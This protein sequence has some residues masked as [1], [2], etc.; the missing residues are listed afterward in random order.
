[1]ANYS[2]LFL[3]EFFAFADQSNFDSLAQQ[4]AFMSYAR[5][6]SDSGVVLSMDLKKWYRTF[7]HDVLKPMASQ[8][9]V[10]HIRRGYRKSLS[11]KAN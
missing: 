5:Y 3:D 11:S 6:V 9:S 1:M 10:V 4:S 7:R 2:Q 8:K